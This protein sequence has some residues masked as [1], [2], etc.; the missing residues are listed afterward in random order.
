M[1]SQQEF[2]RA[3]EIINS[4]KRADGQ[5][6]NLFDVLDKTHTSQWWWK[7]HKKWM[8]HRFPQL[9]LQKIEGDDYLIYSDINNNNNNSLNKNNLKKDTLST[10]HSQKEIKL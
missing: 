5:N 9:T 1:A 2:R 10:L 3:N 7:D 4:V 8:F 6:A